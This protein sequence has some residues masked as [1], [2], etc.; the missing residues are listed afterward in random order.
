ML[1]GRE[2]FLS[3][4]GRIG[5][6][7]IIYSILQS[8]RQ[9]LLHVSTAHHPPRM[10]FG[11]LDKTWYLQFGRLLVDQVPLPSIEQI[12]DNL[13]VICFN[14]DRCI[15]EFLAYYLAS[16]YALRIG[17]ARVLVERLV[18][19]RPYGCIAP[20]SSPGGACSGAPRHLGFGDMN[21]LDLRDLITNIKTYTEQIEDEALVANIR[22]AMSEAETVVFLGFAFHPQN[23]R[24]I[25]REMGIG[26]KRIFASAFASPNLTLRTSPTTSGVGSS[27]VVKRRLSED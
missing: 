11:Q 8:E 13:T 22:S 24:L 10:D 1:A 2:N 3:G 19:L 25:V 26:A 14:Y 27:P 7:A 15:E 20:I 9:S 21:G 4:I 16:V 23:L 5:R 17:D 12:F 6:P 18:I